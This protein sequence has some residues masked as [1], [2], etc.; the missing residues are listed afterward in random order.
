MQV[1]QVQQVKTA[2]RKTHHL[3]FPAEAVRQLRCRLRRQDIVPVMPGGCLPGFLLQG[4]FQLRPGHAGRP[5]LAH[6]DPGSHVGHH[7]GFRHGGPGGQRRAQAGQGGITRAGHVKNL[8][9]LRG[10]ADKIG[11]MGRRNEN[12]AVLAQGDEQVLNAELREQPLRP[13]HGSLFPARHGGVQRHAR[14]LLELLH[15]RL[16]QRGPLVAGIIRTLRVHDHGLARRP[17]PGDHGGGGFPVK[18]AL[19]VIRQKDKVRLRQAG[20][21]PFQ[22]TGDKLRD[23]PQRLFLV[24]PQQMMLARHKTD[25]HGRLIPLALHQLRNAARLFQ[26]TPH[27]PSMAVIA[28]H[29]DKGGA[30]PQRAQVAHHVARTAQ[31]ARLPVHLHDGDRSLRG[32]PADAAVQEFVQHYVPDAENPHPGK[33]VNQCMQAVHGRRSFLPCPIT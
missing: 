12:H 16:H 14:R 19:P 7:Q 17:A 9:G 15:I 27:L 22:K 25:L 8:A 33:S 13:F 11:G 29:A 28:H 26:K 4:L 6:H 21:H 5:E 1:P 30:A 18:Q 31:H 2:V 10:N 23:H 3:L 24:R 20:V 32:N